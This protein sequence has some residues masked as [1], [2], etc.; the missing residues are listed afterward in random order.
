[1]NAYRD[2]SFDISATL[3]RTNHPLIK[4]IDPIRVIRV[5]REIFTILLYFSSH[6]ALK[7]G[8]LTV[9]SLLILCIGSKN[10]I[11]W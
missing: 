10:N 11:P 4:K 6:S 5:I 9:T 7:V 8:E 1:M 2:T 3:A